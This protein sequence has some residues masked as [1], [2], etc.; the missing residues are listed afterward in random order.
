MC[1]FHMDMGSCYI[2]HAFASKIVQLR[3][4]D[5][6]LDLLVDYLVGATPI[7][8]AV[9]VEVTEIHFSMVT[10]RIKLSLLG[11]TSASNITLIIQT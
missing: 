6:V 8:A 3:L 1:D 2:S 11:Q 7:R 4:I 9:F 10:L 5:Y